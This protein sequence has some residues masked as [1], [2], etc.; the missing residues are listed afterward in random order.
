MASIDGTQ[1]Y[2]GLIAATVFVLAVAGFGL[3][4]PGY[5]QASHPVAL[6]GADGVPHALGFN[7]LAFALVGGL[8][9]ATG[10]SLMA[11]M[12]AK[13]GWSLRVGGQLIVLAGLAFLGMGLLPL[14]PT[15]LDGRA[16]QAHATAWL[17]WAV[18]FVPAMLLIAAALLNQSDTRALAL[19]SLGA[20]LLVA[21]L[22]F[23][24]PGLLRQA[25][26][27]RVAFLAWVGW[28]AV[29]GWSWPAKPAF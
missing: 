7:L 6:L 22:A 18:A 17:L 11:R 3:A 25:I 2:L 28:L 15:D 1:R 12:P 27:Q 26:A 14:D 8:G 5:L 16:S 13:S 24:P 23:G 9:M 20:G 4:L 21:V 29:A 10:I 19:L